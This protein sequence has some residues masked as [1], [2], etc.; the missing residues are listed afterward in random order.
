MQMTSSQANSKRAQTF[1]MYVNLVSTQEKTT[2]VQTENLLFL[3]N[4]IV[5]P[6][7]K[8]RH[9]FTNSVKLL[10]KKK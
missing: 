3:Y 1:K 9:D 2:L 6:T 10:H 7:G 5:L 4:A 8:T